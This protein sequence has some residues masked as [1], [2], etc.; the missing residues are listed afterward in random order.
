M[1]T[2]EVVLVGC[3]GKLTK[4]KCMY[5]VELKIYGESCIV[6]VLVVPGQRDD[7][8]IGTNVIKFLMRRL[9]NSDDYWRLIYACNISSSPECEQFLNLM[10][11]T[12]CW[13]GEELPDKV[14][15]V[16]LKQSVTLLA[17]PEHLVW[18]KLPNDTPMSPGNTVIVQ[19]TSSKS[20]PRNIMVGRVMTPLWGDGWIPMKV[21]NLSDRPVMLKRNCKLADVSPCLAVE[22][23]ELFQ[24]SSQ[25]YK[26]VSVKHQTSTS[27]SDLEQ[28]L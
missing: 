5:E 24:G 6:P 23:F 7:L 4:P 16:K 21:T 2:Q 13:R 26:T 10:A 22:D 12:S 20:M 1:M 18:A 28:I 25:N 14:G 8:I 27:I 11:N 9:K 3:G 19:P 15:T 17:K